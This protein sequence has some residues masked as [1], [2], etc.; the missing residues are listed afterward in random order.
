MSTYTTR[1][2]IRTST[3]PR[4]ARWRGRLI[5]LLALLAATGAAAVA[6]IAVAEQLTRSSTVAPAVHHE[7]NADT[8]EAPGK[9]GDRGSSSA[10]GRAGAQPSQEYLWRPA[11]VRGKVVLIRIRADAANVRED[12]GISNLKP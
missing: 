6:G 8:G 3:E 4:P 9:T 5:W 12:R 11:Y 1:P 2:D 10:A 7:P